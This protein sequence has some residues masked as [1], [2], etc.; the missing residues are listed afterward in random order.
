M[1]VAR[2]VIAGGFADESRQAVEL[3]A[4]QALLRIGNEQLYRLALAFRFE[5]DPGRT[6]TTFPVGAK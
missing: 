3:R 6:S 1:S 5:A 4:L 2:Q